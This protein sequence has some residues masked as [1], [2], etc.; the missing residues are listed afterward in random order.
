[1]RKIGRMRVEAGRVVHW[2]LANEMVN[3]NCFIYEQTL[4]LCFTVYLHCLPLLPSV[5]RRS[6][7]A[8]PL[9]ILESSAFLLRCIFVFNF[10]I[11]EN[12]YL[13][14]K[15]LVSFLYFSFHFWQLQVS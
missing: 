3:N 8:L 7:P 12:K 6:S 10:Q 2:N 15:Y 13:N 14:V 1:M 5:N 9:P 4:S 11:V